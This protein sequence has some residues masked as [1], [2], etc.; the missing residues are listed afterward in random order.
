MYRQVELKVV[1]CRCPQLLRPCPLILQKGATRV[2][3][4]VC[5]DTGSRGRH[6][7]LIINASPYPVQEVDINT[8]HWEQFKQDGQYH[9][10]AQQELEDLR[11]RVQELSRQM[12]HMGASSSGHAHTSSERART[13]PSLGSDNPAEDKR[14][15]TMMYTIF[16]FFFIAECSI[17]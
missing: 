17:A 5:F 6:L 4:P 7:Y 11:Q 15:T 13:P 16:F 8:D 14:V 2:I 12:G 3:N 10:A 9:A 1:L